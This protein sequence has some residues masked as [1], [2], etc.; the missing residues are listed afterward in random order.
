MCATRQQKTLYLC[1]QST[2]RKLFVKYFILNYGISKNRKRH[3]AKCRSPFEKNAPSERILFTAANVFRDHGRVANLFSFIG[4]SPSL[5][6][7]LPL[8]YRL[9]RSTLHQMPLI[10]ITQMVRSP[11]HQRLMTFLVEQMWKKR[12]HS[13][14]RA[15]DYENPL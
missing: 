14:R 15:L 9:E 12:A 6:L 8:S 2:I 11:E 4:F 1:R 7:L 3:D 10:C 13:Q 5:F